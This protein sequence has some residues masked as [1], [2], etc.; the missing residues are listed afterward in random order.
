M[1]TDGTQRQPI[2]LFH[3]MAWNMNVQLRWSVS[4]KRLVNNFYCQLFGCSWDPGA[5]P[6]PKTREKIEV[7][8]WVSC[9]WLVSYLSLV[10][11][12]QQWQKGGKK[13]SFHRF[14][15]CC[16]CWVTEDLRPNRKCCIFAPQHNI[17]LLQCDCSA[18]HWMMTE[19]QCSFSSYKLHFHRIMIYYYNWVF[20]YGSSQS[21]FF[22][23]YVK[24]KPWL[25]VP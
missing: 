22:I 9:F 21:V 23:L 11:S 3:C 18:L 12:S 5:N 16:G 13:Y 24:A 7:M 4:S 10:G 19:T 25:V 20:S 8:T 14:T 6:T 2:S 1:F 15:S 17:T